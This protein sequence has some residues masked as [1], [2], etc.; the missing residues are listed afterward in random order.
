MSSFD[1][2][3]AAVDW[4]DA[5]RAAKLELLMALYADDAA[6]ECGTKTRLVGRDS[7]AAYWRKRFE[8]KPAGELEDLATEGPDVIISYR[9]PSGVGRTTMSFDHAG[10]IRRCSCALA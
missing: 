6:L 10:K 5:Y 3:A 7:I 4:L 2:M 1:P 8:Q 9:L